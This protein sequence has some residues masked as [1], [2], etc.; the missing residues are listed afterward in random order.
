MD[1]A[2]FLLVDLRRVVFLLAAGLRAEVR[3]VAVDFRLVDLRFLV[4]AAFLPAATRLVLFRRV[5]FF[6]VDF[7]AVVLRFLVAA[8]FFAAA[9]RFVLFRLRVAAAFLAAVERFLAG[10][11]CHPLSVPSGRHALQASPFPFAH[12]A[13]HPVAL[14]ATECVVQ[15]LDA[16][17]TVSADPLGLPR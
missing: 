16:N 8:A 4:A 12:P 1:A 3:F 10:D 11:M 2:A 17:G 5:V 7:L 6:A 15:A 9:E 13:P 14:V